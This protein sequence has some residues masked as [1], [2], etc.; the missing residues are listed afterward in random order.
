MG[1]PAE[2]VGP[3]RPADRRVH[4]GP[5]QQPVPVPRAGCELRGAR[6][7]RVRP[8]QPTAVQARAAGQRGQQHQRDARGDPG[9]AGRDAGPGAV[10]ALET[11]PEVSPEAREPGWVRP[12]VIVAAVL[13]LLLVGATGGLLIGRAGVPE[14][15]A[16]E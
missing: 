13:V 12:F 11:R 5:A 16:A 1:P 7:G 2:A 10:T 14:V 4:P 15:P 8:G 3:E 9:C 6:A